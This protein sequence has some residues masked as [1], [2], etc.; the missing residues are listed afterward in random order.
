ML[1]AEMENILE[2]NMHYE[3]FCGNEELLLITNEVNDDS[4]VDHCC[5]VIDNLNKVFR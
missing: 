1:I 3:K 2:I 5:L 4:I